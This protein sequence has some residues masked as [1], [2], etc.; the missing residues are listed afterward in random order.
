MEIGIMIPSRSYDIAY[1]AIEDALWERDPDEVVST[2]DM[3]Q[4]VESVQSAL[5]DATYEVDRLVRGE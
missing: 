3:D 5:T 1:S 4:I 2:D